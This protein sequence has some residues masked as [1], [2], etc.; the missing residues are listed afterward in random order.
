MSR[1]IVRRQSLSPS[2]PSGEGA[3]AALRTAEDFDFAIARDGTWYHQGTAIT[4]P[5]LVKLFAGV[6]R[7]EGDGS[8]WLV[9]PVERARVHV[10][11]A[12]FTAVEMRLRGDGSGS[13]LAFRTN[14]EDWVEAGPD[15]PIRVEEAP[16]TGEPSPYIVVRD[17]LEALIVRSVFYE[18]AELAEPAVREGRE[19]LGVWSH[20]TFFPLGSAEAAG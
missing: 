7:R 18:L 14:L 5:R 6:L 16:E 19:V 8:Y 15:H 2:G 13:V 1:T 9:T 12:P 17:G 3:P 20:G 10:E 4:R 11:D